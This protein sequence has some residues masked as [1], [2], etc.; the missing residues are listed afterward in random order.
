MVV[1]TAP[2][3]SEF[4]K[5]GAVLSTINLLRKESADEP[6]EAPKQKWFGIA[7]HASNY[8]EQSRSILERSRVIEKYHGFSRGAP[9]RLSKKWAMPQRNP[10]DEI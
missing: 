1:G 4:R 8:A 5:V 10:K 9:F 6:Y 3:Q 2:S 7:H